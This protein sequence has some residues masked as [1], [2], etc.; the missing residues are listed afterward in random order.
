MNQSS[1]TLS[2]MGNLFLYNGLHED[3]WLI[4][5]QATRLKKLKVIWHWTYLN[6]VRYGRTCTWVTTLEKRKKLMFFFSPLNQCDLHMLLL[7]YIRESLKEKKNDCLKNVFNMN[8]IHVC[9]CGITTIIVT[10]TFT[11]SRILTSV[12]LADKNKTGCNSIQCQYFSS[13]PC[14]YE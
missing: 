14:M 13:I 9:I 7:W 10:I 2:G 4:I 5:K 6:H 11:C 12:H 8:M 1:D 3:T